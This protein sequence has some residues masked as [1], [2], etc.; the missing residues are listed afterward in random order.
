MYGITADPTG[1]GRC[2]TRRSLRKELPITLGHFL[3]L[4]EGGG[5]DSGG[6]RCICELARKAG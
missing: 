3:E 1:W 5:A 2:Y 6:C 4:L